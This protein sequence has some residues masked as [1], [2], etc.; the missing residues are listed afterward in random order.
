MFN[1]GWRCASIGFEIQVKMLSS[2][3]AVVVRMGGRLVNLEDLSVP[4]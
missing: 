4:L 2:V 3:C 1:A